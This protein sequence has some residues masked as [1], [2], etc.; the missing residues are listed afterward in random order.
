[1]KPLKRRR[2][3]GVAVGSKELMDLTALEGYGVSIDGD[4]PTALELRGT[5][6][7]N[8]PLP[9]DNA[10][11]MAGR[12]VELPPDFVLNPDGSGNRMYIEEYDIFVDNLVC[13]QCGG[14]KQK[15]GVTVRDHDGTL[16]A[17]ASCAEC[18]T[19]L[20]VELTPKGETKE[21]D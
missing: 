19:I 14:T 2:R 13:T 21:G 4:A 15:A 12:P 10:S 9:D 5:T 3:K 1:M 18:S 16:F 7:L 8:K 11:A 6:P 17:V 20:F